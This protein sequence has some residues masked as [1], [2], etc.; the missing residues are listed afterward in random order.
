M[1]ELLD[2]YRKL[3]DIRNGKSLV[4]EGSVNDYRRPQAEVTR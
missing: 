3:E 2:T 4:S 1:R